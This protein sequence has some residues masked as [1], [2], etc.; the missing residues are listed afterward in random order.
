MKLH[1]PLVDA[2]RSVLTDIFEHGYYA[3]KV[4]E[5]TLKSNPKMGSKDR[6]FVAETSYD[7]VRWWRLLNEVSQN[8]YKTDPRSLLDIISTYFFIFHNERAQWKENY[9]IDFDQLAVNHQSLIS[10]PAVQASIP[11]WLAT[12]LENE[13]GNQWKTEMEALN[14]QAHVCLRVNTL[15]T[16]RTELKQLLNQENVSTIESP[17]S[18]TALVLKERKNVFLSPLFKSGLFELQDVG[19]QCI[20]DFSLVKPGMRVVDACAGA[21]GKTLQLAAL[22][23]NKGRILAMDTDENKLTE[24]KR[25]AKRAGISIIETRKIESSKTIKRLAESADLVLL[26]V[27]CSGLGT[28]R[29]NPDVKWKLSEA[30]IKTVQEKQVQILSSYSKMLKPGGTLIYATCSILPS[31]NENQVQQFLSAHPRFQLDDQKSLSPALQ[32]S[33]GFYMARLNYQLS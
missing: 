14:K 5:R 15:K 27:P 2:V 21:G 7:I 6:G 11:D 12:R 1:F 33:D 3:D 8:N 16:E 31:E 9:G 20:G 18:P 17:F 10:N 24:L 4:I 13:I 26:D 23:E 32:E 22:M 30:F 29:R 25:R 19:S 28:L